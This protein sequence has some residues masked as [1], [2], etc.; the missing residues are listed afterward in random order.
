MTEKQITMK[1]TDLELILKH[2]E[3]NTN[4]FKFGEV[5]KKITPH[6]VKQIFC[7]PIEGKDF[8]FNKKEA[9]W[10]NPLI[11]KH[12]S[13]CKDAPTKPQVIKA[14]ID[15]L[16]D[17]NNA[18]PAHVASLLIMSLFVS[19][20]FSNSAS[21]ITLDLVNVSCKI[22][23]ISYY[24]WSLIVIQFLEKGLTKHNKEKPITLSSCLL[25][26]L[27]WFL[28][29]TKAKAKRYIAG[30]EGA[31]PTFIKWSIQNIFDWETYKSNPR[32]AEGCHM[33]WVGIAGIFE[34]VNQRLDHLCFCG[35][36]LAFAEMLGD[37]WILRFCFLLIEGEVFAF[38]GEAKKLL[39]SC[40]VIFFTTSPNL[41]SFVLLS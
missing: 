5:V 11:S 30:R 32:L 39:T 6:D 7:L 26:I 19:F 16:K 15:A 13:K 27:Y 36:I 14:L 40:G 12:F 35:S 23:D 20:L 3:S 24:T 8:T 28:D 4:E 18:N 10:K 22:K 1:E 38:Y 25:L 21:K 29:N 33:C 34:L 17:T 2:Y 37:E 31:E 41:N 9:K